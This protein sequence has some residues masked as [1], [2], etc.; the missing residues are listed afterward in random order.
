VDPGFESGAADALNP[1][2]ER[3]G[4]PLRVEWTDYGLQGH[5]PANRENPCFLCAR[6]RRKRLFEVADELRC[7]TLALGHNKDDVIETLFLNMCYAGEIST[8]RPEQELFKGRFRLIRP[9]AYA[10]SGLIRRFAREFSLPVTAN[11]CPSAERSQRAEIKS[12]LADLYRRNSKI[13]GNIFR[14]L[15]HVRTDY[16]LK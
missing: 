15:R 8:M 4:I 14:A 6:L 9:L 1:F 5:S 16:L 10:E 7:G 12:L 2:C 3:L 13:K 11:P